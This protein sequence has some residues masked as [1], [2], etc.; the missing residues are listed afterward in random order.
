MWYDLYL[1]VFLYESVA[2]KN[3]LVQNKYGSDLSTEFLFI[4]AAGGVQR[5]FK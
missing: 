2:R 5:I 3:Y 4:S 1:S